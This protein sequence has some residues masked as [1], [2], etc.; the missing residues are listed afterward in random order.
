MTLEFDYS[1][2]NC[3][4]CS[5]MN[6][7]AVLILIFVQIN[8]L[9]LSSRLNSDMVPFTIRYELEKRHNIELMA[10]YGDEIL[11]EYEDSN[12]EENLSTDHSIDSNDENEYFDAKPR[13]IN[14]DALENG[15]GNIDTN[16]RND[17]KQDNLSKQKRKKLLGDEPNKEKKFSCDSCKKVFDK[18][19]TLN[20]H[21]LLH[22]G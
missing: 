14:F 8:Y 22:S 5:L 16:G 19:W 4:F 6:G 15:N 11:N 12:T 7:I 20:S 21:M 18:R 13:K 17:V 9:L 2:F 1:L 10:H 3:H